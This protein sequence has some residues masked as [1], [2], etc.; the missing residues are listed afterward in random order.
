VDKDQKKI[1]LILTEACN[2]DC[3]YCYEHFKSD[4]KMSFETAKIIL[5]DFYRTSKPGDTVLIEVFGGEP[6][7]N[8]DLI[9]Q[10][11]DYVM[12]VYNDRNTF[13]ETT[14]NGTLVHGEIQE[15]LKQR[16]D[17]YMV[18]LSLDGTEAM[19]NKTDLCFLEEIVIIVLILIFLLIHGRIAKLN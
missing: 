10:I 1:M 19:Q 2:L 14:T 4:K 8:F 17:R 13:F 18:S 9:K 6:F 16:K 7:T 11:D 3:V 12:K 15:W 5:D